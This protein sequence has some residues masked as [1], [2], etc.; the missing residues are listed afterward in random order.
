MSCVQ[1]W[2]VATFPKRLS[3]EEERELFEQKSHGSMHARRSLIVHN[4]CLV[5]MVVLREYTF[6]GSDRDDIISCGMIGL[7][8][9]VD[10]FNYRL[11][12]RFSSFAV[13]CIRNEIKAV[14]CR[15][16]EKTSKEIFIDDVQDD[17]RRCLTI[18]DT[19]I[20]PADVEE[21]VDWRLCR[22]QVESLIESSLTQR[23]QDIITKRYGID[24]KAPMTQMNV[25]QELGITYSG[26]GKAE[27]KAIQKLKDEFWN[28]K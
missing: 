27:K 10:A 14:F 15:Q 7:I 24:G 26:V 20:D 6:T 1:N 4:M 11:G 16:A 28:G 13:P 21:S 18:E 22:E 23:Q 8:K 12:F 5:A 2:N 9:A 19:L 3:D 17:D 25:A